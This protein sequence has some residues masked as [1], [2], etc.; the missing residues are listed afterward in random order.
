MNDIARCFARKIT[1]IR[2]QIDSTVIADMDIVP[3]DPVVREDT[4]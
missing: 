4:V 3:D 2:N 1:R